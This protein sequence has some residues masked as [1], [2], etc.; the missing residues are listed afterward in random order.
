M[1]FNMIKTAGFEKYI[2]KLLSNAHSITHGTAYYSC[3]VKNGKD[4]NSKRFINL[5]LNCL[6]KCVSA[7]WQPNR[8]NNEIA[9]NL[10]ENCPLRIVWLCWLMQNGIEDNPIN[11]C[12]YS[13]RAFRDPWCNCWRDWI[14]RGSSFEPNTDASVCYISDSHHIIF[15]GTSGNGKPY[16]AYALGEAACRKLLSVRYIRMPELLEELMIAKEHKEL[17]KT[18]KAYEKIDLLILDEWL[19]RDLQLFSHV[20]NQRTDYFLNILRSSHYF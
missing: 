15:K 1:I 7:G 12:V 14:L 2:H 5:R 17:K 3:S 10:T 20:I 19:D 13:W 8:K 6:K 9:P 4:G 16:W 18:M 11:T